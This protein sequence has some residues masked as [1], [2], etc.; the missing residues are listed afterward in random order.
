VESIAV[1]PP[2]AGRVSLGV[3]LLS[4]AGAV[5]MAVTSDVALMPSP[6]WITT[7]FEEDLV[8]LG[9]ACLSGGS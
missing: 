3:S 2:T 1:F 7:A 4:Y 5:R 8:E 6:E 9:K